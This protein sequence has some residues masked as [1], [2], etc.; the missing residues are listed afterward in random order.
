LSRFFR[1]VVDCFGI[2]SKKKWWNEIQK[3]YQT[4]YAI[5]DINTAG[6]SL[7]D[8][9]INFTDIFSV[10][11]EKIKIDY[12]IGKLSRDDVI[13]LQDKIA[14]YKQLY[15]KHNS[16]S[17]LELRQEYFKSTAIN[18]TLPPQHAKAFYNKTN[19]TIQPKTNNRSPNTSEK[20]NGL[21]L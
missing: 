15:N 10:N 3:I 20:D 14:T 7:E 9:F 12:Y 11:K 18:F 8:S 13:M 6:L 2:Y 4:L 21:H 16:K 5:H 1:T 19:K 17:Y